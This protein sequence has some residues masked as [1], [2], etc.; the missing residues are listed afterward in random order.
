MMNGMQDLEDSRRR[1]I[2]EGDVDDMRVPALPDDDD[3]D[4]SQMKFTKFAATYFQGNNNA[5]Y[6]R[7]VLK[8]PLLPLRNEGDQL[9][10]TL[11]QLLST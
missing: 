1:H 8:M 9:V 4:I 10:S 7:R 2:D 6:I 5:S 3:E 11:S